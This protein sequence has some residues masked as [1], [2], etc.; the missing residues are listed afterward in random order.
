MKT[1]LIPTEDHDAMPAVLEGARLLASMFD[2]YMEGFSVRPS[3]G[4][5]V[6]VE[7]VSSLAISGVFEADTAKARAEFEKFMQAHNVPPG[8]SQTPSVFSYAWPRIEALEDAF[9]GSYGRIFDLIV[10]GRPGSAPENPRMPPLEAALFD[11]GKPVLIVPKQVPASIG[12][13]VLV[14]W[15]GST[16]QAHANAYALPLLQRAEKVTVLSVAGGA[17]DGPSVEEAALHLRRNGVRA[18][19]VMVKRERTSAEAVGEITLEHAA[20]LGCDLVVKSAYTQSR[21]RQM[22][23]GGATRHILANANLPVLM[24]H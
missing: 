12:R 9:I 21:L 4:T 11:S 17:P 3:P 10:L 22:I 7:P 15:N 13:N 18:E 24:A 23:F 8:G 19:A 1:I 2:S 14:A 16:E 6:T 5:Y 20:S